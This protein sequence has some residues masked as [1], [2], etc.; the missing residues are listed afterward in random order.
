[1]LVAAQIHQYSC[2]TTPYNAD[3]EYHNEE[4]RI[5]IRTQTRGGLLGD[6]VWVV[7]VEN[8]QTGEEWDEFDLPRNHERGEPFHVLMEACGKVQGVIKGSLTREEL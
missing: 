7:E 4:F 6:S 3:G 8:L 2:D 1:M 5:T